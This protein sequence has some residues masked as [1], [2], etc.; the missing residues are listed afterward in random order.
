MF[1]EK[2]KELEAGIAQTKAEISAQTAKLKEILAQG[3]LEKGREIRADIDAKK[4]FLATLEGDLNLFK[5]IKGEP[6]A[7][8][9][10]HVVESEE[11]S[12]RDAVNDWLHSKGATASSELK[13]EGNDLFIPLNAIDPEKG[14]H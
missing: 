3:D 11:K 13:F 9:A 6:A 5:D 10:T 12:T 2:I 4:E 7:A 8:A 1:D 14:R